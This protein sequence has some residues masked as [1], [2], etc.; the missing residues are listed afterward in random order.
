[1]VS[2]IGDAFQRAKARGE[3]DKVYYYMDLPSSRAIMLPMVRFLQKNDG[4]FQPGTP[5]VGHPK[6]FK[7]KNESTFRGLVERVEAQEPEFRWKSWKIES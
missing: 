2:A 3:K 6:F 4:A 5:F 1:M 7:I